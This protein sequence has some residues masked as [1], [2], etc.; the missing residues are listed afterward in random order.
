[1]EYDYV[2]SNVKLIHHLIANMGKFSQSIKDA[3][4]AIKYGDLKN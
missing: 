4:N 1:M 3:G 2:H